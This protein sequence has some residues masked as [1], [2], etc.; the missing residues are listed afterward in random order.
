MPE[1]DVKV[2]VVDDSAVV[3]NFLQTDLNKQSGIQVVAA[4]PDPYVAREMIPVHRPD[5]ITLDIEMPRMDGLTFLRKLMAHFPIPTIVLSS[6]TEKGSSTALACLEAGA[7]EVLCKPNGSFSIGDLSRELG[8]CIRAASGTKPQPRRA[9]AGSKALAVDRS[10]MIETTNKVIAIGSSTGGTEALRSVLEPLPRDLPGILI[11]QHMPPVFTETF[12]KRLN[13]LCR[14]DVREAKHGDAVVPGSVLIAPGDY[15]MKLVRRGARYLV[16]VNQGPRV[17]RHRPS[18][19]VLFQSVAHHAGAN[20]LGVMLTGMG[21]DGSTG[22]KAMR[23]SGAFTIAQ[24][25][26]TCVVYGM[27][28]AAVKK[29]AVIESQPLSK[30]ASRIVDFATKKIGGEVLVR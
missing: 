19:E 15:H 6:L 27:P 2:L 17:C 29:G 30:I 23:D 7:F 9:A 26:A 5:V 22:M 16:E 28:R 10:A 8:T 12:A 25:E 11:T 1:S 20:A 13:E 3:R 24:D 21:D 14:L 4:A 18:V